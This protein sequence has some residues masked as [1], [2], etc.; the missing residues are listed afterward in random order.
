ME[1]GASGR[2]V[3][4]VLIWAPLVSHDDSLRDS[5]M[6]VAVYAC[7]NTRPTIRE[8]WGLD[9]GLVSDIRAQLVSGGTKAVAALVPE[10][11]LADLA[12]TDL[13][14][15]AIAHR[16]VELGVS[17]MAVPGYGASPVPDQIMWALAVQYIL[18]EGRKA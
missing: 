13:A 8:T 7:L 16:A 15:T 2:A 1:E 14:P 3:P 6:H 4:P 5:T 10:G 9:A 17:E 12:V 11:A 18:S